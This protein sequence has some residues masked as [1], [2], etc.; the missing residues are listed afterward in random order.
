MLNNGDYVII[1]TILKNGYYLA[2]SFFLNSLYKL[3]LS[4]NIPDNDD[5]E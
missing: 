1:L 5:K 4:N 2:I 3:I